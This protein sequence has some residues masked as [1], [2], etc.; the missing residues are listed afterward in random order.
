[1]PGTPGPSPPAPGATLHLPIR[2][3][4]SALKRTTTPRV[5]RRPDAALDFFT[6][7]G[8]APPRG[9]R[10]RA[11]ASWPLEN[12]GLRRVPSVA[13]R[14]SRDLQRFCRRLLM[15][16]SIACRRL[17]YLTLQT[18]VATVLTLAGAVAIALDFSSFPSQARGSQ[19]AHG[20]GVSWGCLRRR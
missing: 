16:S 18:N 17:L 2:F 15:T 19:P 20:P 8:R 3:G 12:H 7:A 1:M 13:A 11:S 14:G 4:R 10:L 5:G 6:A 9:K